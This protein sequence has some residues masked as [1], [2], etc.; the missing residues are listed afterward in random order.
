MNPATPHG[1]PNYASC[2][3]KTFHSALGHF[4]QTEFPQTFGPAVT[5][6]F[7][8]RVD[9]LYEQFHPPRT[10]L[11]FGQV[12][13]VAVAAG[14]RPAGENRIENLP[15]VPLVLDLVTP[16][17]IDDTMIPNQRVHVRANKVVRLFRQAFA[18]GGVLSQADVSLLLHTPRQTVGHVLTAYQRKTGEVVPTR[19]SIHDL[20]PTVSHKA[21]ICYKRLVEKK[22]TSQV[23][24]ETFHSP[25][26]VEYYVQCLRRV[27]LCTDKGL[28]PQDTA[29][30]TN[31]SLL[32]VQEYL[33]LIDQYDIRS[34]VPE[35]APDMPPPPE[36][37]F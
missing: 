9:A 30:A 13:W 26:E 34:V 15:L 36:I 25:R 11:T 5:R 35:L 18:Q 2:Q 6:L 20:G 19:G 33:K 37:P 14:H 4:L 1:I 22:P 17:D 32:L 8:D 12:V 23:A 29:L 28:S 27:L 31:H 3:R 21:I 16:Q 10:R 7:V 24:Q